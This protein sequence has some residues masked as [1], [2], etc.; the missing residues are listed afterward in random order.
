MI[1]VNIALICKERVKKDDKWA[2]V[3]LRKIRIYS[4]DKIILSMRE[5]K[6]TNLYFADNKYFVI[7]SYILVLSIT[8]TLTGL[9]RSPKQCRCSYFKCTYASIY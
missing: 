4:K 8:L 3:L 5:R 7:Q 1:N 9:D 2:L 6:K